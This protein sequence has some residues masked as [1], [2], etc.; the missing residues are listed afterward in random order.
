MIKFFRRAD[1]H[2]AAD[3]TALVVYVPAPSS[4]PPPAR[5]T[6]PLATPPADPWLYTCD[7]VV[8]NAHAFWAGLEKHR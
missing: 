5:P 4:W 8:T 1:Q 6:R 2:R 7:T 3:R